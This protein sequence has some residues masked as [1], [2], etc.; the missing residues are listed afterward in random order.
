MR[1]TFSD[2]ITKTAQSNPNTYM[3][4]GD[5]GYALFD[6]IRK[7]CPDQFINVGVAEQNMIGLAAGLAKA[8][9][10]PMVYGLSAFVP[11]RVLE[12]IKLDFCYENLPGLIIG[13]GAGV[14]YS[15]LGASHQSF[16]DIA[17]LRAVP[18][19]IVMSPADKH[20]LV[21]CYNLALSSKAPV[22][23]RLGKADLPEVHSNP[24][25]IILKKLVPVAKQQ[26]AKFAIVATGSMLSLAH[27]LVQNEYKTVDLFSAPLIKPLGITEVAE[28]LK[29]YDTIITME[30]HSVYGGLGSAISEIVVQTTAKKVVICGIE[31][32]FSEVCGSYDYLMKLQKLDRNSI[33]EKI[34]KLN[35][36]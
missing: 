22:Y 2:L 3:L 23:M 6:Q 25:E 30:E 34:K 19:I 7:A 10:Y 31:D 21:S 18:N 13:D 14:V 4:T 28:Q 35:I 26:N 29:Q 15:S 9:M 27:N 17:C 32:Q 12:Q 24:P 11:V 16:E 33:I 5:H 20:E 8:G 1:N 36:L